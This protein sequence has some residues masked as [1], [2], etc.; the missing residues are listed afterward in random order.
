MA[1][2]KG[3]LRHLEGWELA[4]VAVTVAVVG[5]FL[6]VPFPVTPEDVPLP[7]ADER[8]LAARERTDIE[9]AAGVIPLL[10][11]DAAGLY[12]LRAFG[13]AFRAYGRAEALASQAPSAN[14][15][16]PDMYEG[17]RT[18]RA[19][20]DAVNRARALGDDKLRAVR[21]YQKEQFVAQLET[22]ERTQAVS[23]ELTGLG[24]SFLT[25]ASRYG[26]RTDR[27]LDMSER[28][29]GIFFERRWNEL[30]G[31]TEGAYA[32]SL[33]EYRAF[34]RFL[35]THPPVEQSSASPKEACLWADEWRLRKIAEIARVDPSYPAGLARGVLLYRTGRYPAAAD[36]LRDYLGSSEDGAYALRARNYL[37]EASARAQA[38]S[39]P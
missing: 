24:G 25:L 28:L 35:L 7:V 21:A 5:I 23:E 17:V 11:R 30:T 33:D 34:Y 27:K 22:W 26:W 4:L 38:S 13:E 6:L 16:G 3:V 31:L 39:S 8:A 1:R 10:E 2:G 36:A 9:L 18:R 37:A 19:L 29:R 20:I 12:D 14:G 15:Q 32:L